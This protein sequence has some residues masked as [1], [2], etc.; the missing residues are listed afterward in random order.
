M[1][2]KHMPKLE[3]EENE[4]DAYKTVIVFL[5]IGMVLVSVVIFFM[6]QQPKAFSELTFKENSTLPDFI[7]PGEKVS[8]DI[9]I[10][11]HEGKETAYPINIT[12]TE[13][14]KIITLYSGVFTLPD[15]Q[16]TDVTLNFSIDNFNK[17]E[18]VTQAGNTQQKLRFYVYN[19]NLLMKYPDGVAYTAC[20]KRVSAEPK[21]TFTIRAKG[22]DWPVMKVRLDGKQVFSKIIN[23]TD[24]E[25]ITIKAAGWSYLDIVFDNDYYN[26]TE[27]IDR[28]L[29]IEYVKIGNTSITPR[30][31]TVDG[32]SGIRAFDCLELKNNATYLSSNSALRLKLK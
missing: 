26:L 14:G 29:Y 8:F 25:N 1:P 24:Y 19:S 4:V 3:M 23:N 17:S 22:K 20:V 16:K 30:N 21:E 5:L 15:G 11:N 6:R 7:L 31:M 18:I 27:K 9:T 10:N 32:G 13:N 12:G 2:A 28:N